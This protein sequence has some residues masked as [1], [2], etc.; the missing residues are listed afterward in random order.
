MP[1][2]RRGTRIVV[3]L[4]VLPALLVPIA[5]IAASHGAGGYTGPGVTP[6]FT[7]DVAPV[8][9][10]KCAG[11]HQVGGIAPFP[12][13]TAS[14]IS[15]RAGLIGATVQ[16]GLMPPWPPGGKSP[17][18][19]GQE[20]RKLTARERAILVSWARAGGRTNGPA[21]GRPRT[22]HDAGAG[23]REAPR[24]THADRLPAERTQGHDRRL[25]LLPPRPEARG[26]RL[27]HLGADRP[28]RS[29]GRPPRDPLPRRE[30]STSPRRSASTR[31]TPARAGRA[32]AEPGCRS[33]PAAA[34][35]RTA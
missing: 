6:S 1:S 30:G 15:S 11:C 26:R 22:N 32:S 20:A 7:R 25:S 9:Q 21:L 31:P 35:S 28:W 33:A 34:A 24:P 27:R 29:E 23:G 12:L 8:I 16:A 14:Q 13:E 10:Q 19:V 5:A 4:A 17:A 3:A 18:Y 2:V